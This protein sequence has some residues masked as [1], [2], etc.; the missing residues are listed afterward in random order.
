MNYAQAEKVEIV[1]PGEPAAKPRMTRRDIWIK[2]DVVLNYRSW[3]DAARAAAA[4]KLPPNPVSIDVIAYFRIPRRPRNAKAIVPGA[5]H[6]QR[7]D[8]DNILKAVFDSL[9]QKDEGIAVASITKLWDDGRGA[10]T[11]VTIDR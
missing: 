5:F 7:P 1:I 8:A 4:G 11:I 9:W 2:R 3:C 6:R 10:R